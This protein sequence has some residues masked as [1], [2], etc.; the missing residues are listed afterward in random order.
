METIELN[1]QVN[2]GDPS[3]GLAKKNT[4][5]MVQRDTEAFI[6]TSLENA[7]FNGTSAFWVRDYVHGGTNENLKKEMI[8]T[9][10]S[11]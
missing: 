11:W 1:E 8:K 5:D 4:I 3:Q 9:G 6:E 7:T 2:G 10:R